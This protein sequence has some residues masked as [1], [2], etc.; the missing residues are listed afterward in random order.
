MQTF[1]FK[2]TAW[3]VLLI[4]LL[5]VCFWVLSKAGIQPL[6]AAIAIVCLKGFIRFVYRLTVMLVSIAIV[7]SLIIF[8]I[9]I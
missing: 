3:T 8:L 2:K 7:I 6:L 1:I 5:A 4:M 9:C